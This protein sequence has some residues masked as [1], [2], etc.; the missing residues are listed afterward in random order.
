MKAHGVRVVPKRD[1]DQ[2]NFRVVLLSD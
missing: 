2:T 1:D